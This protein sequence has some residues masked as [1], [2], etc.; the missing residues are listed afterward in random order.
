MK[1]ETRSQFWISLLSLSL[2][3][4]GCGSDDNA[5]SGGFESDLP[6]GP[7]R[8]YELKDIS[9]TS[10]DSVQVSATVGQAPAGS[11]ARPAVILVH[12][13]GRTRFDWVFSGLFEL[14]MEEG[15]LPLS[16]DL[17]GHGQTPLPDDGR[18][19]PVFLIA[20]FDAF[21][22]DVLAA[23]TWLRNQPTIDFARVAVIGAGVGGNV[24]YVSIGAFPDELRAGVAVSPGL[25]DNELQPLVI[26]EGI[27]PFT[28]HH[29]LY[30]V[31]SDDELTMTDGGVLSF[32]LFA[33]NLASLTADPVQVTV[34]EGL[35][36]HGLNLFNITANGFNEQIADL[37]ISWLDEH[38]D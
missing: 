27:D 34:F 29:M 10:V 36:A 18:D 26:G 19:S 20:D 37:I 38:L 12:D 30:M 9:F 13:L 33:N 6:T 23:L 4:I 14:F 31:G 2:Y 24:A 17:R 1:K 32:P 3:V 28:P 35:T 15:Y 11:A 25:W 7:G 22:F 16:I 5:G 21:H 8:V